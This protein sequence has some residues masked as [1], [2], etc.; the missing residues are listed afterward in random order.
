MSAALA[1]KYGIKNVD[2]IR[3]EAF[4]NGKWINGDS[5]FT[6]DNPATSELIAEVVDTPVALIENEAIPA[7][8]TAF[9]SFKKT[10]GRY[11]SG[12][13]T[14]MY[15]L[16][17]ENLDDLAILITIENGKSLA[18]AAGEVKY[19]AS[20]YQWFAEEAPRI[21][22]DTIPSANG[23]NRIITVKQP[24]GV[25]GILTPWNFPSAMITRKLGAALAAGCTAVIKPAAETPLSALALGYIAELA[26]VPAGVVNLVPVSQEPTKV[27][28]KLFCE[29][30]S[31][32]KISFTGSTGVGKLLMQQ[33]ASSLKKLSF[34][35]GGNAPFIVFD[36]A[37][38]D[39]AVDGAIACKLR[40]SGQTCVCANRIY[41]HSKV[42]DEFSTKLVA[43]VR[44]NLTLGNGLHKGI[45]HGPLIH[46]RAV[47]KVQQH[48]E[49]AVAKGAKILHG[50]KTAPHL[51]ENFHEITVVG[52]VTHDMLVSREE[53]FGPLAPLIKFD[54]EDEAIALAN[55]TEFGLAGYFYTRDY[56]RLF[57]VGEALHVGMAGANTGAI[58]EAAMPFGGVG[59]SGFGREGSKYG[60]EDYIVIKTIVIGGI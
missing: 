6:V 4:V 14:R 12:L 40:Q 20:F 45:T 18:D 31:I 33:S 52:D 2:L 7:A 47:A 57:R 11:R 51:G 1:A 24:I 41:V 17:M 53:T 23:S 58:S 32:R 21:Y 27:V 49:D 3:T 39:A 30:P 55:S 10:T 26:G 60:V 29:S 54:T 16:M 36:D 19:A 43:K 9:N 37:D 34:E 28:G 44:D 35:L 5:K 22:G 8:V 38:I 13:L 25:V 48:V 56:A 15:E 50:G 46:G 42:Y 59:H